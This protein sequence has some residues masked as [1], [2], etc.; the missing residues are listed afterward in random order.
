M[1][2]ILITGGSGQLG[3]DI[4]R[5]LKK[6][7]GNYATIFMPNH[8]VLDITDKNS[9]KE[10]IETFKPDVVFHAAAYT[11][12]DDAE[13]NQDLCYDTNVY[14]TQN[15]AEA[16]EKI[17]AKLI[18]VSSDYVFDGKKDSIYTEGDAERPINVYGKSKLAGEHKA[19]LNPKTFIVRTSWVFGINGK[20][21]VKTMLDL[22][23]KK[24]KLTVVCDQFGSPTYT[25]DLARLLVDMSETEKYGIY[26]A[27]NEGYTSWYKFAK[28]IFD[29][30]NKDVYVEPI[31]SEQYKTKA[32]RPKNSCLSKGK[33]VGA[34]FTPLPDYHDA[35]NRFSREL[36]AYK[37]YMTTYYANEDIEFA[38]KTRAISTN[39]KDCYIIDPHVFGD[40]RGSFTPIFLAEY[41]EQ[42]GFRKSVQDNRSISHKGVF[43]GLHFQKEPYTQA[44][45]V[46]VD[47]G[48]AFVVVV[49]M[50]VDSPTYL[51]STSLLLTPFDPSDP[52]SGLE[53][54]VP[55]GFA[56]G[57]LA[58][59]DN[60]WYMYKID[61]DYMP[62]SEG[63]VLWCDPALDIDWKRLFAEGC[64][65]DD[66]LDL[67]DADK[68][69]P[70]L[71]G[72]EEYFHYKKLE[73][74]NNPAKYD[75]ETGM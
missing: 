67:K 15:I 26:N 20:N 46:Y 50:R 7:Y 35:L 42:L 65:E 9:V 40:A 45:I 53:L 69:R 27:T 22:A 75:F 14:A 1:K 11:K 25:V 37:E 38:N 23:D 39:L 61:N 43:R 17:G 63:G 68:N 24:D 6:R 13:D 3:Y 64:I 30:N 70:K 12:V 59:K 73:L 52:K 55:A 32:E 2:K 34:G 47:K 41:M 66:L 62:S 49:D 33:L 18:Y 58:L 60:T 10:L 16:C 21:F 44:K 48:A 56:H 29:V 72:T 57:Y 51:K 71:D 28:D 36:E 31:K 4:Y 5:E 19:A 54:Y 74:N 8:A